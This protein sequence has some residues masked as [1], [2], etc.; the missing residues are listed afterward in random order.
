M[1]SFLPISCLGTGRC[2]DD[3][4]FYR[5]LDLCYQFHHMVDNYGPNVPGSCSKLGVELIRIT[6][7]ERQKYVELVTGM[8]SLIL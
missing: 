3:F 2:S 7:E 8:L 1:E 6:S 4:L 5:E